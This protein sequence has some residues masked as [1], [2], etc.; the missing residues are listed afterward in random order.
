MKLTILRKTFFIVLASYIV[1]MT[2]CRTFD[3]FNFRPI[4]INELVLNGANSRNVIDTFELRNDYTKTFYIDSMSA[5]IYD[6]SGH[7]I[8]TQPA[9]QNGF[10]PKFWPLNDYQYYSFTDFSQRLCHPTNVRRLF[11]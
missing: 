6:T 3:T 4:V 9:I 5:S 10:E 7:L 1:S 2:G 11:L 8:E